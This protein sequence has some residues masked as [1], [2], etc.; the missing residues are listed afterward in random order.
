MTKDPTKTLPLLY[1]DD[2]TVNEI[3]QIADDC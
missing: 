2:A 1:Y 3:N